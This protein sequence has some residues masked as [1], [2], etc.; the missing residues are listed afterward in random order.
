MDTNINEPRSESIKELTPEEFVNAYKKLCF[1]Y[2]FEIKPELIFKQ[3]ID[4]TFTIG[5]RL[6]IVKLELQR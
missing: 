4:G 5:F 1:D 6:S 2:G 3:Q